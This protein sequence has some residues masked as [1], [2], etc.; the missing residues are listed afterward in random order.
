MK[1]LAPGGGREGFLPLADIE[2]SA[3]SV[4]LSSITF[5]SLA[6]VRMN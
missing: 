1:S 3:F 5:F 4:T 6:V 2:L